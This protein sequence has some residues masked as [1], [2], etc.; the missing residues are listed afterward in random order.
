[1]QHY[2]IS[3]W[4]LSSLFAA[5]C[6]VALLLQS[7]LLLFLMGSCPWLRHLWA[8]VASSIRAKGMWLPEADCLASH[9]QGLT[10]RD[11]HTSTTLPVISQQRWRQQ[12]TAMVSRQKSVRLWTETSTA[13]LLQHEMFTLP[14][15][16]ILRVSGQY[17][18]AVLSHAQ[19]LTLNILQ[20]F[21]T[22]SWF[23]TWIL[24]AKKKGKRLDERPRGFVLI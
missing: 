19:C 11:F 8:P 5:G 15:D 21:V 1:M 20:Y 12:N 16:I 17:W 23:L 22:N 3:T 13:E 10:E 18:N 4:F 6:Q 24:P 7:W 14:P 9:D 2:F